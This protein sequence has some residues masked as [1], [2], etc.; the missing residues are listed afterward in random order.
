[1]SPKQLQFA[2][3]IR[4][5]KMLPRAGSTNRGRKGFLKT[6]DRRIVRPDAVLRKALDGTVR[7]EPLSKG[8]GGPPHP[9]RAKEFENLNPD[10]NR[11]I[12]KL[13]LV[14]IDR[15]QLID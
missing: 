1:M 9:R 12:T 15:P 2:I 7:D 3:A 11:S 6:R 5:V 4:P 14:S 13:D 8:L 10:L